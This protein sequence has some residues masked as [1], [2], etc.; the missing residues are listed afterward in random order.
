MPLG[1]FPEYQVW[2]DM[3]LRCTQPHRHN[4]YLY[5]G[6]GIRVCE[7]WTNSFRLFLIDMGFRP[8]GDYSIDRIDNDGNYEP[9]NCRWATRIE[10]QANSRPAI[11]FRETQGMTDEE[12][13]NLGEFAR[14]AGVSKATMKKRLRTMNI[15]DAIALGRSEPCLVRHGSAN[16]GSKFKEEDIPVIRKRFA[17]GESSKQIAKD[18]GVGRTAIEKIV[19]R[20]AWKHVP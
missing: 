5:G 10:Q 2:K 11:Q 13:A 7:R 18:Y 3:I 8:E 9:S 12:Y 14:E 20:L 4:Y 17:D 1:S 19:H 6:R 15:R 16:C